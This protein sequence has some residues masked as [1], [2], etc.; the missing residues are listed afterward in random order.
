MKYD[1]LRNHMDKNEYEIIR[2]F[3]EGKE[4]NHQNSLIPEQNKQ[5]VAKYEKSSLQHNR[6]R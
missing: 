3:E 4:I 1:P 2:L 6:N 5:E